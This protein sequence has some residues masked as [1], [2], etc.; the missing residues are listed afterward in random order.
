MQ[1]IRQR[2][3]LAAKTSLPTS[4]KP[5]ALISNASRLCCSS[6]IVLLIFDRVLDGLDQVR[7]RVAV[8][9]EH[10]RRHRDVVAQRGKARIELGQERVEVAEAPG[11]SFR[12]GR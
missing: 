6:T 2:F 9:V 5:I 12:P 1:D 7:R 3:R 4:A 10:R 11:R 8:G